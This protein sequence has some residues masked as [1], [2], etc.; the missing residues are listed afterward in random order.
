[1]TGLKV[2]DLLKFI[3][4]NHLKNVS[5]NYEVN[6]EKEKDII[7]SQSTKGTIKRKDEIS[8]TVSL[9]SQESLKPIKIK[10][11][12][13]L[14]EF[15]ATLY[16][17]SN[18]IKYNITYEFNSKIKRGYVVSQDKKKDTKVDPNQDTVDLVISKGKEI[19]VPDFTGKSVNDVLEWISKNNLKSSFAE[20]FSLTVKDGEL[21]GINY[22]KD[23]K[24]EEG[25]K[26]IITTSKGYL[27]VPKFNSL[28]EFINWANANGIRYT[29]DYQYS[30]TVSKGNIISLSL[31][32]G[33]K[34]DPNK[35]SI[36]VIISYG[37]PVTI[38]NFVGKNKS[39]ITSTCKSVGLN[40]NFYY[41]GYSNTAAD[42]ATNQTIGAG[43]KVVSGTYIKIGLS[44]GPAKT[45]SF[46][47]QA[48]WMINSTA[49]NTIATLK[50]YL[51]AS[52]PGVTFNFVKKAHTSSPSGFIHP[53]SPVQG[54][55]NNFTQ[56]QTYTIWIVE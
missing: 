12:T 49:D 8:F 27:T 22:N 33:A 14:S 16:L 53:S 7:I 30:N 6:N 19:N 15:D 28:A 24:L 29:Q 45:Y 17:K 47:I 42:V 25:T 40:C 31:A 39:E 1:M 50:K 41:I 10:D 11:L 51:S 18:G 4:E 56:G 5:I 35:D 44:N 34:V 3:K 43:N 55:N 32:T 21:I 36:G 38:P 13:N 26:I 23:D 20:N 52:C 9:G 46:Y 54:G 48:E 2:D 37:A